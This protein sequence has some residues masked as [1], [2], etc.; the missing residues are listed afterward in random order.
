MIK[1]AITSIIILSF[2]VISMTGCSIVPQSRLTDEQTELVAEYSAGLL[3]KYS[4]GHTDGLMPVSERNENTSEEISD[5]APAEEESTDISVETLETDEEPASE[6]SDNGVIDLSQPLGD[7]IAEVTADETTLTLAQLYGIPE[8][9]M[10]YSSYEITDIYP[11][12]ESDDVMFASQAAPG[13]DLLVVHFSLTNP[14]ENDCAINMTSSKCKSRLLV[15]GEERIRN[16]LTLLDDDF[17]QLNTTLPGFAM[18]DVV[19]VFE[20]AEGAADSISRLSLIVVNDQGDNT[21]S[22]L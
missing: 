7:A 11:A 3:M 21:F 14:S 13:M 17:M 2:L 1:K 9:E 10:N 18:Q 6:E 22:L 15:N 8:F 16:Q 20:I 12:A 5:S 4:K 19:M